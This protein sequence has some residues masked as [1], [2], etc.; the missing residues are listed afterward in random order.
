MLLAAANMGIK[1]GL[2][3]GATVALGF[4]A[5]GLLVYFAGDLAELLKDLA[6][7]VT[8]HPEASSGTVVRVRGVARAGAGGTSAAFLG[9]EPAVH[10]TTFAN[11]EGRKDYVEVEQH[12]PPFV[13]DAGGV[14]VALDGKDIAVFGREHWWSDGWMAAPSPGNVLQRLT[15]EQSARVNA[16]TGRKDKV[17]AVVETVI[18]PGDE[19]DVIAAVV[20]QKEGRLAFVAPPKGKIRVVTGKPEDALKNASGGRTVGRGLMGF[21]VVVGAVLGVIALVTLL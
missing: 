11:V 5:M 8:T 12:Q 6:R 15:P 16:K 3:V 19:I 14:E 17:H 1:V 21:G 7:E 20:E 10:A 13:L 18:A 2:L 9:G 4:V